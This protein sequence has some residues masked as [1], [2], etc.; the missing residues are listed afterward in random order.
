M[1]VDRRLLGWGLFFILVGAIPL[2]TRAGLL[3]PEVVGQWLS[4]WPLLLIAWGIGLVLR[5]TR[6]DWIGGAIAAVVFGIMA[7]GLLATGFGGA[8]ISSGCG[9][10]S[11]GTAFATQSGTFAGTGQLNVELSCGSL[12]MRSVPGSAWSISGTQRDGKAPRID[13]D[14]ASVSIDAGERGS[15]FGSAGRTDWTVDVPADPQ[16]GLGLTIN[17]GQ[18][19][20]DLAGANLGPVNLTVNAGSGRLLL[21][22]STALGD[23]NATVNAGSAVIGLPTGA[24]AANLSLNAGS[25]VVCLTPGT[26][27]RASWSGALGSNDLDAS[28][29]TKVDA[30]TWQSPGFNAASPFLDLRVSANAGSFSLDIDGTCDA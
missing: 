18:G 7:G 21:G 14:G 3:D 16:L 9:G 20:M 2:A 10:Q 29:L 1:R 15:F 24:R 12:T 25:L 23:L 27:V 26:Q 19:A 17:A 4:L 28:G 11:G 6:I 8:P 30:N 13:I 22:G 5:R